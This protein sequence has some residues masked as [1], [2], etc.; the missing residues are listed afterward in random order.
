MI[1][2]D[3]SKQY[4]ESIKKMMLVSSI[5]FPL[6]LKRKDFTLVAGL[7]GYIKLFYHNIFSIEGI[8]VNLRWINEGINFFIR[9]TKQFFIDA[10]IA[11]KYS[12]DSSFELQFPIKILIASKDEFITC[13]EIEKRNNIEIEIIDGY[14]TWF[15]LNEKLLITKVFDYFKN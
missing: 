14:H 9:H 8:K 5:K 4:P 1:A 15:F 6:S 11:T 2:I 13:K 12:Q 10:L 3:Y 7:V